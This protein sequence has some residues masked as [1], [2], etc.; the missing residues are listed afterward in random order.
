MR[1]HFLRFS[2]HASMATPYI[3]LLLLI[4][5][6]PLST[7]KLQ[8]C[9][10]PLVWKN[11]KK[12]LWYMFITYQLSIIAVCSIPTLSTLRA[13][14]SSSKTFSAFSSSLHSFIHPY[15]PFSI[16]MIHSTHPNNQN[17]TNAS[18]DTPVYSTES[19]NLINQS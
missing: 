3:S 2:T 4:R 15:Q 5:W 8:G 11:E 9:I 19:T 17:W 16:T 7:E 6:L 12:L 14:C 13:S 1:S 10:D 18:N